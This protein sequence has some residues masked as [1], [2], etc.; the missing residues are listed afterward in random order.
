MSL[1]QLCVLVVVIEC[2]KCY[3]ET[4]NAPN[5]H[6]NF[7]MYCNGNWGCHYGA[8]NCP[9]Y[10][11]CTVN[12]TEDYSCFDT[13]INCPQNGA[14]TVECGSG[15]CYEITINAANENNTFSIG[16]IDRAASSTT[17]NCPLFADCS[18][19]CPLFSCGY[20]QINCPQIGECQ[21]EC[22][23][24]G[25]DNVEVYC[26][27]HGDC[28]IDCLDEYSCRTMTMHCYQGSDNCIYSHDNIGDT[29]KSIEWSIIPRPLSTMS[30]LR[31]YSTFNPTYMPSI[32]IN[33]TNVP[34]LTPINPK[35]TPNPTKQTLTPTKPKPTPNPT[36]TGTLETI[37][38]KQRKSVTLLR[39]GG[40][41]TVIIFALLV[42]AIIAYYLKRKQNKVRTQNLLEMVIENKNDDNDNENEEDKDDTLTMAR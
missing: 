2:A 11:D 22:G 37:S 24:W 18:I 20:I 3:S 12:C 19:D 14:C 34:S 13:I 5:N 8:I 10:A 23:K 26:P 21:I 39:I 32:S 6:Q 27:L 29:E 33:P 35:P 30:K 31:T 9:L 7:T 28:T 38:L 4:W 25:C 1:S 15:G 40:V 41:I 36:T 16:S 42:I 17:I